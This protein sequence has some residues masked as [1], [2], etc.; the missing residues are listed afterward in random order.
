MKQSYKDIVKINVSFFILLVLLFCFTPISSQ[1]TPTQK[2]RKLHNYSIIF[3]AVI[4]S[5]KEF[6]QGLSFISKLE[7]IKDPELSPELFKEYMEASSYLRKSALNSIVAKLSKEREI[8]ISSLE[9]AEDSFAESLSVEYYT[10]ATD[11]YSEG[12]LLTAGIQKRLKEAWEEE[13]PEK[14]IS[15]FDSIL[16]DGEN[17]LKKW[18]E[19]IQESSKAS[20]LSLSQADA[21]KSAQSD[22][23]D[24]ISLLRKY[25]SP[26]KNDTVELTLLEKEIQDGMDLFSSGK[27]KTAFYKLERCRKIL[28][29]LVHEDFKVYSKKKIEDSK[30]KLENAEIA[31]GQERHRFMEDPEILTQLEDNLRAAKETI[32]I[33]E[34]LFQE[35][36]FLDSIA[37]SEESLFLTERFGEDIAHASV[38]EK[39][40]YDEDIDDLPAKKVKEAKQFPGKKIPP[41]HVVKNGESLVKISAYYFQKKINWKEIYKI[42]RLKIK[43]PK[44]IF[45]G[46]KISLPQK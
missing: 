18:E 8:V 9:T 36:K 15:L 11:L 29:D 24:T 22:L 34:T 44:L 31:L 5:P 27:I 13:N 2:I 25:R 26:D 20:S 7:S 16:E 38:P 14:Q 10:H 19:S 33:A 30:K 46:Q 39:K 42:N 6:E 4:F 32:Q 21:L 3:E 17:C 43:N 41:V 12:N 35:D 37:K 23:G 1:E 40:L 45:S 28:D